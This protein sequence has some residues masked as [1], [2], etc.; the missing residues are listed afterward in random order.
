MEVVAPP[1]ERGARSTKIIIRIQSLAK[2]GFIKML[3]VVPCLPGGAQV[4]ESKHVTNAPPVT[5]IP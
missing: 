3:P 5:T 2:I 4:P 1:P